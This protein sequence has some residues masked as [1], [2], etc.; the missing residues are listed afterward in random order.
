MSINIKNASKFV[1]SGNFRR[2]NF[3]I[4]PLKG[5][6]SKVRVSHVEM[7]GNYVRKLAKLPTSEN[8][9]QAKQFVDGVELESRGGGPIYGGLQAWDSAKTVAQTGNVIAEGALGTKSLA[10]AMME[11]K[12]VTTFSVFVEEY[13]ARVFMSQL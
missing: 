9:S 8:I 6:C 7:Q 3:V 1:Y 4:E 12:K 13:S 10:D 11:W 5:L 2:N